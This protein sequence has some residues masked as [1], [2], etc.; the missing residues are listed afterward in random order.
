MG[1]RTRYLYD[2]YSRLK[3]V[4]D[5]MNKPTTYDYDLMKAPAALSAAMRFSRS[6]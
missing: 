5:P 6:R 2:D 3:A 4:I 1:R